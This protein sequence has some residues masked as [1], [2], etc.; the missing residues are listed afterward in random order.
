ME[1]PAGQ[2]VPLPPHVVLH[3]EPG[4]R[5]SAGGPYRGP[6]L[7]RD[8]VLIEIGWRPGLRAATIGFVALWWAVLLILYALSRA[9]E[10][11][12]LFV[13]GLA[14]LALFGLGLT[15]WALAQLLNR[16]VVSLQGESLA[17]RF[18]P[19]PWRGAVTIPAAAIEQ[20]C[21]RERAAYYIH[22]VPVP[23]FSVMA[24]VRGGD[25]V[26]V[27]RNLPL[28]AQARYLEWVLEDALR[29]VDRPVAG[30][31]R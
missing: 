3:R 8:D 10:A 21:V 5:E 30:E 1:S 14:L 29:V 24:I 28:A 7:T 18:R 16:T 4:A 19:L 11:P 12:W 25:E 23:G 15:Y 17:V 6:G 22:N 20:L 26:L 2:R 31:R 27:V 13:G 9:V